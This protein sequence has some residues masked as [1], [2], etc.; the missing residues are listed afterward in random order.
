MKH[1]RPT[2]KSYS[3]ESKRKQGEAF[4]RMRYSKNIA[5]LSALKLSNSKNDIPFY[6]SCM[7][8]YEKAKREKLPFLVNE[9]EG[10]FINN[11]RWQGIKN[12]IL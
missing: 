2:G 10:T 4:Y 3:I 12:K 11:L 6:F 9:E 5:R 7:R 1:L 8:G